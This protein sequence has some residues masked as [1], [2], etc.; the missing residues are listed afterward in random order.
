MTARP[1]NPSPERQA[2]ILVTHTA[3]LATRHTY[4]WNAEDGTFEVYAPA[5][6][7]GRVVARWRAEHAGDQ[8]AHDNAA[9]ACDAYNK[10][11]TPRQLAL[12]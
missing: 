2:R 5:M 7:G 1:W 3:R 12:I 8:R 11:H 9:A 4:G 6:D 10:G